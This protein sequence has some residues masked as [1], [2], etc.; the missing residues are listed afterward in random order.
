MKKRIIFGFFSFCLLVVLCLIGVQKLYYHGA[1]H[2]NIHAISSAWDYDP[3]P[4]PALPSAEQ[5]HIDAILKQPFSYL[6]K[7]EQFYVFESQD[8]NY[9]LK[10]FKQNPFRKKHSWLPI[11]Q[12]LKSTYE[13]KSQK[14]KKRLHDIFES[15]QLAYLALP[16]ET[17]IV[18]LHLNKDESDHK[19]LTLIDKLGLKWKIP[20]HHF[21]F[22]LQKKGI[23][24]DVCL[25][26]LTEENREQ[27][28]AQVCAAIESRCRKNICDK[29]SEVVCNMA[30]TQDL[31]EAFF[32]DVGF[33]STDETLSQESPMAEELT[34]RLTTLKT[35]SENNCP[36]LTAHVNQ[37]IQQGKE[38][39][40][41]D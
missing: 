39:L 18:Y 27:I 14:R 40:Q 24:L 23:P 13:E 30:M 4:L 11:S 20:I 33:F 7:G 31:Q 29:D 17:G 34:K 3:F 25:P 9:V 26:S 21:E 28:V 36:L 32:I 19:R 15:C 6:G 8:H 2:F 37:L 16:K 22:I 1:D 12:S 38:Q 10:F 5:E 35:W 41:M